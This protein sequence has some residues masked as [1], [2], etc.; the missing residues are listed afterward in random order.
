[1]SRRITV[2]TEISNKDFA[3][4]AL[5]KLGVAYQVGENSITITSGPI[6][7]GVL[8]LTTGILTTDSD[9]GN[10]K[11]YDLFRQAYSEVQLIAECLKEGTIIE[12]RIVDGNKIRLMW[13]NGS[14]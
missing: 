12:Q 2:K 1:M 3:I 13:Y 11:K 4:Q 8:D 9:Y 7:R 5:S 6:P 14:N 10:S